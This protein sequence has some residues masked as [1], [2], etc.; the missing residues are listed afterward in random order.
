[1]DAATDFF[2]ASLLIVQLVYSYS[3]CAIPLVERDYLIVLFGVM[4]FPTP[5]KPVDIEVSP[6]FD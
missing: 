2:S 3:E 6:L 1:M 4:S 5:L